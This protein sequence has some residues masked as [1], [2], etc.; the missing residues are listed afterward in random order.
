MKCSVYI[1]TSLDGFIATP[2]GGVDWLDTCGKTDLTEAEIASMG[3]MGF[4]A[5]MGSIDCLIMG[6]KSM[7]TIAG[8]DLTPEQWPY[9]DTRIIVLS[10]TVTSPPKSLEGKVELYSGEIRT[11]LSTLEQEG[12][13]HAYIDGGTTI[14]AF[15]DLQEIDEMTIT[16]API[17]LGE[18]IPLFGK[19]AQSIRLTHAESTAFA[20]NFIQCRYRVSYGN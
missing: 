15:L 20:N 6:R 5:L 8:M 9:G 12:H 10:T 18:G 1:A 17:L 4:G 11:L 7:D 2:N 16:I 3:D 14:R 13:Q 19:T